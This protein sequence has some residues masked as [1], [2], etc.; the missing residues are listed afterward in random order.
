MA[1]DTDLSLRAK[2]YRAGA[3]RLTLA[4]PRLWAPALGVRQ[5][6]PGALSRRRSWLFCNLFELN[7]KFQSNSFIRPQRTGMSTREE[8]EAHLAMVDLNIAKLEARVEYLKGHVDTALAKV[9]NTKH[10]NDLLLPAIGS[11]ITL[12]IL[13]K[14]LRLELAAAIDG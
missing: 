14:R 3:Y 4:V 12:K 9:A 8:T 10:L 2:A 7:C 11:L 13:R 5:S 6:K 1:P